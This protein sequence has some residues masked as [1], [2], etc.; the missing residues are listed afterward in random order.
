MLFFEILA[1]NFENKKMGFK[2]VDALHFVTGPASNKRVGKV[3]SIAFEQGKSV[4]QSVVQQG[5]F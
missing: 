5:F 1:E 3:V 4:W 2:F